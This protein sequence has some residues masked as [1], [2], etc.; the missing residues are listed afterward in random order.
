M[1]RWTQEPQSSDRERPATRFPLHRTH[2]PCSQWAGKHSQKNRREFCRHY[3]CIKL[4]PNRVWPCRWRCRSSPRWVCEA[5]VIPGAVVLGEAPHPTRLGARAGT[6]Q[7]CL[8]GWRWGEGLTVGSGRTLPQLLWVFQPA[9]LSLSIQLSA[10]SCSA[11]LPA[12]SAGQKVRTRGI[13]ARQEMLKQ[14][15]EEGISSWWSLFG[16]RHS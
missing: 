3:P 2:L 8:G 16:H 14:H 7:P 4:L 9:E 10:L 5:G 15:L 1:P 13:T 11:A 12:P 6:N